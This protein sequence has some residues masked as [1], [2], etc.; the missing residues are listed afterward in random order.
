MYLHGIK[1]L[2][3]L[4]VVKAIIYNIFN[5]LYM[6]TNDMN[7]EKQTTN[8][9]SDLGDTFK[10]LNNDFK[11][12]LDVL[13]SQYKGVQ[14][15]DK[16]NESLK[17]FKESLIGK[18]E[19]NVQLKKEDVKLDNFNISASSNPK[20]DITKVFTSNFSQKDE[21]SE[22]SYHIQHKLK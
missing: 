7:V 4:T 6:K 9:L 1:K 8:F 10:N 3:R 2:M 20:V 16:L 13:S 17:N 12:S 11:Q 18:M 22:N 19:D 15:S 5:R 14:F 21:Q